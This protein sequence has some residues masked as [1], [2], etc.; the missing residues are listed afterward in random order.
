MGGLNVVEGARRTPPVIWS[1]PTQPWSEPKGF[2]QNT[3][4]SKLVVP[5]VVSNVS[6]LLRAKHQKEWF[7]WDHQQSNFANRLFFCNWTK[8]GIS[9]W[10]KLTRLRYEAESAQFNSV[11]SGVCQKCV[12]RFVS[13]WSYVC[14]I[15]HG[16]ERLVIG[17]RK[18]TGL[19][20]TWLAKP[21]L[22]NW[23]FTAFACETLCWVSRLVAKIFL[24]GS[25][26]GMLCPWEAADGVVPSS[27]SSSL[28]WKAGQTCAVLLVGLT[29]ISPLTQVGWPTLAKVSHD[30]KIIGRSTISQHWTVAFSIW[31]SWSQLNQ[32]TYSVRNGL[33][34]FF[35]DQSSPLVC[36]FSQNLHPM[37]KPL[38][39]PPP[40][41]MEGRC[42]AATQLQ[43]S[44]HHQKA[45]VG[46]RKQN[47]CSN[48]VHKQACGGEEL[49][50]LL[51]PNV[52]R[53]IHS[54]IFFPCNQK[55]QQWA[56]NK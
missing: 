26:F 16:S 39:P 18:Y 56:F 31:F 44:P 54:K 48:F 37:G 19:R 6:Y 12:L 15:S 41:P 14:R 13:P 24:A 23:D 43:S 5:N 36:S 47:H 20:P 9:F 22:W 4:S 8:F 38:Q 21:L 51:R 29:F 53:I 52:G 34:H 45:P 7:G 11:N 27:P 32:L 30:W 40:S 25:L 1:G 3:I 35:W 55:K 10:E 50:N 42:G 17:L 46:V 33:E 2:S 49:N 28:N